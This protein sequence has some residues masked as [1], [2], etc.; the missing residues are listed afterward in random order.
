MGIDLALEDERGR[1]IAELTDTGNRFSTVIRSI[2]NSDTHCIQYIAPH[3]DTTFN[4]LQIPRLL[5]ELKLLE[6][7]LSDTGH[8]KAV[9][10]YVKLIRVHSSA[11]RIYAKFYGD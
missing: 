6:A 4:Q 1:R 2:A 10:E 9:S 5:Q 8:S 3:M 7:S 11:P